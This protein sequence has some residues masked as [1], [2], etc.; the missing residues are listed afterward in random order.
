MRYYSYL[1]TAVKILHEYSGTQPLSVFIKSF[2]AA[3]KKYGSK[4]RKQISHLCY[5]YFRLGHACRHLSVEERVIAGLFMCSSESHSLLEQIKPEWNG[6]VALPITQKLAMVN[7][8]VQ[9]I[10]PWIDVLSQGINTEAFIQS[11][12]IQPD[13]FLRIRPGKKQIVAEKLLN[14]G[15]PYSFIEENSIALPNASKLETVLLLNKEAVV[16]DYSS[17]QVASFFSFIKKNTESNIKIWDCCAASGGKS[18]LAKDI[19]NT[20]DLTVSDIRPS[21]L[22]NLKARFAEAGITSYK[23]FTA[24]L[25]IAKEYVPDSSFDLVICDVPCSGSG[26]WA[27]TPEELYFFEEKQIDTFSTLQKKIV[28]NVIAAVKPGGFFLYITCSV[29]QQEN[30]EVAGYCISLGLQ[31][32]K[33]EL[34]MGYDKKADTMFAALFKKPL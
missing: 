11:F 33:K 34:I 6:S 9:D 13:L 10:F 16:Q 25:S 14:A 21:I 28:A 3:D 8:S 29:F 27:R 15:I 2:F 17:Q 18:I 5:C 32:V 20:I 4:D 23:S 31:L 24:D 30:D 12:F 1:N 22:H 7:A 19:F 26:T